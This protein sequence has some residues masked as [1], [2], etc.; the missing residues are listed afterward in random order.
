MSGKRNLKVEVDTPVVEMIAS[1]DLD[2]GDDEYGGEVLGDDDDWGTELVLPSPKADSKR[3]EH[4]S[5][6]GDR[7][8]IFYALLAVADLRFY[9][10][11]AQTQQKLIKNLKVETFHGGDIIIK[12]GDEAN[13]FYILLA[14]QELSTDAEVEVYKTLEDGSRKV[15]TSLSRGHYFGEKTFVSNNPQPRNASI[16]VPTSCKVGVEIGIV[17]SEYY[18]DWDHFRQFLV[19]KDVPLI[20]SLPRNEQLEMYSKLIRREYNSNEFIIT[21]GD[22]GEDFYI[23]LEGVVN[24]QDKMHGVLVN[25]QAGHCFGEMALLSDEPRVA[26]VVAVSKVVCL[27]LS[28]VAFRAALSAEKFS[29]IVTDVMEQRRVTRLKRD[30]EREK[31]T[32]AMS[33]KG[34]VASLAG[35]GDGE[36]PE[37]GSQLWVKGA[38]SGGSMLQRGSCK[39]TYSS[40]CEV[41]FSSKLVIKKIGQTKYINK[42]RVVKEIGKGSFGS[43]YMVVNEQNNEPCAMKAV[44]RSTGWNRNKVDIMS[45]IEIMK[46]LNHKNIVALKG[47]IDDLSAQKMF[48]VQEL[49][50][51]GSLMNEEMTASGNNNAPIPF[52]NDQSRKYFRDM[53]KAVHYLHSLGIIHRD[54]KPQNILLTEDGQCKLSDFG[55][56]ISVHAKS[57]KKLPVAGTPAFMATELFLDPTPEVQKAPAIDIFALG[58]TL[59]CMV[60]GKVPW[61]AKNEIDLGAQ[62]TRFE[63]T[64]PVEC[65]LDPHLKVLLLRMMEKDPIKRISLDDIISNDWVTC[66]S[67]EP[68][69]DDFERIPPRCP[70]FRQ[71]SKVLMNSR[72]C[73]SGSSDTSPY[74][75]NSQASLS[76]GMSGVIFPSG[77]TKSTVSPVSGLGSPNSAELLTGKVKSRSLYYPTLQSRS[78]HYDDEDNEM[79]FSHLLARDLDRLQERSMGNSRSN[80]IARLVP[81]LSG[82]GLRLLSPEHDDMMGS[83]LSLSSSDLSGG[84]G[85]AVIYYGVDDIL[86]LATMFS[87][88][89]SN[90]HSRTASGVPTMHSISEDFCAA[91]DDDYN[92]IGIDIDAKLARSFSDGGFGSVKSTDSYDNRTSSGDVP[93]RRQ[94]PPKQPS[95]K[96]TGGFEIV[97]TELTMTSTGEKISKGI[98]I[99]TPASQSPK[100][101]RGSL[102]STSTKNGKSM[103]SLSSRT[104]SMER[105][106]SV[107]KKTAEA[108]YNVS[109]G[110]RPNENIKAEDNEEDDH[111]N[112]DI[113]QSVA[114]TD[115]NI[116]NSSGSGYDS[117][118]SNNWNEVASQP[119]E[120]GSDTM[121]PT[122]GNKGTFFSSK[123]EGIREESCDELDQNSD[124]DSDSD[125]DVLVEGDVRMKGFC[126]VCLLMFVNWCQCVVV[127]DFIL[128]RIL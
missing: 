122:G 113:S 107:R 123:F 36:F 6:F 58:A 63:V 116:W 29:A 18:A 56:A 37:L 62:I 102:Y 85:P 104:G 114:S 96:R 28:K 43:V 73:S 2:D 112:D 5:L 93:T 47:V 99:E 17:T 108:S 1:E 60:I 46:H 34:S 21:E 78:H 120:S 24:V 76:S 127:S 53:V 65:H 111:A 48:I 16:R 103:R 121:S 70:L 97:P 4:L 68:M 32:S 52:S 64:F 105:I 81:S 51:G 3:Q 12:E 88:A 57:K 13:A 31:L 124:N 59:Y 20:K 67:S 72:S 40:G 10:L 117:A 94:L 38:D 22:P 74:S 119:G 9:E 98:V 80:S 26:S 54:I 41:T 101:G 84:L 87:P 126:L 89:V 30:R 110:G 115:D 50:G 82:N 128:R 42:Y 23:I 7:L 79:D 77:S 61:M 71:A 14:T 95:L 33:R 39:S 91:D 44:N 25:L 83:Q 49:L 69:Y 8:D 90:A 55:S 45:E 92:S 86:D 11:D 118:T 109:A 125:D 106:V 35:D 66:E 100:L 75:L 15:L 27:C 19:M